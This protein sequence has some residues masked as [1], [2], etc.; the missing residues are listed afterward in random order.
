LA[1]SRILLSISVLCLGKAF[2]LGVLTFFR[3]RGVVVRYFLIVS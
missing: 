3:R 1:F 2:A